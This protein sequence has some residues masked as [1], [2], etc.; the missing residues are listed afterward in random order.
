VI[1]P[2]LANVYLHYAFDLWVNVWREKWAH[3]EVVVIRYADDIILGLRFRYPGNVR[4]SCNTIR[5]NSS[6]FSHR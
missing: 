1:S 3:G 6:E 4:F 5:A 2:L